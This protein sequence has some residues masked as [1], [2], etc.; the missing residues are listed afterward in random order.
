MNRLACFLPLLL[1]LYGCAGTSYVLAPV[2][3]ED[4]HSPIAGES[5]EARVGDRIFSRVLRASVPTVEVRDILGTTIGGKNRSTQPGRYA[6]FAQTATGGLFVDQAKLSYYLEMSGNAAALA[7][8]VQADPIAGLV[9]DASGATPQITGFFEVVAA[10]RTQIWPLP[11]AIP[12]FAEEPTPVRREGNFW[13]ELLYNGRSGDTIRLTY[14][15]YADD[16]IRA[17]FQ[18]ELSYDL[19][20]GRQI[21]FKGLLLDV[22]EATNSVIRYRVRQFVD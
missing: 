3:V 5:A 8:S 21:G 19:A 18:Q 9:V 12:A 16:L 2:T 1:S 6:Q 22:E 20:A 4:S 14:R 11:Q 10:N 15:E 13:W 7:A 17:S